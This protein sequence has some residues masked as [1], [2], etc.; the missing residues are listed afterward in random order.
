MPSLSFQVELEFETVGF[1]GEE[2]NQGT[3]RK[4]FQSKG[5]NQQQ[6]LSTY[7]VD[8]RIWIQPQWCEATGLEINFFVRE[9]AGD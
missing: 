2:K 6:T 7:D 3:D 9:P 4:T 8:T 1:W 5:E